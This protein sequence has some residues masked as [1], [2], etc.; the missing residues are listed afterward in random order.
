MPINDYYIVLRFCEGQAEL[1]DNDPSHHLYIT[2]GTVI[3]QDETDQ[4]VEVGR[5][6]LFY[7]H[8]WA[9][10]NAGASVFDI[11]DYTQET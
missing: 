11:F 8:V 2:D 4:T 9:A 1:E 10:V 7:I 5:F 3:A 6:R